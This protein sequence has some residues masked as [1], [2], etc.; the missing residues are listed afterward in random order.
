MWNGSF[1]R[2]KQ[3]FTLVTFFGERNL[4]CQCVSDSAQN[5]LE[6]LE[7][8]PNGV[9]SEKVRSYIYQLIRA[10]HWCHKHDIVHRGKK[11]PLLL[12]S[13]LRW[14]CAF[15]EIYQQQFLCRK[16]VI[17]KCENLRQ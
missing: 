16:N 2:K 17:S 7:E 11:S 10:I 15:S 14:L 13:S 5:M 9:P 8:L 4:D 12:S 6:L 1:Y 3:K